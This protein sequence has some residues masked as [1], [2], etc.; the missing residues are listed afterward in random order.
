MAGLSRVS[1]GRKLGLEVPNAA[2]RRSWSTSQEKHSLWR[3]AHWSWQHAVEIFLSG[4][5]FGAGLK[6][7][8]QSFLALV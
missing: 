8:E 5:I 7:M 2:S 4:R 6:F 3:S 1:T